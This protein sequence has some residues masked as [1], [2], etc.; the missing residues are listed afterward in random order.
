MVND[1]TAVTSATA[2]AAAMKK[3]TGMNKD[4]FLQLFVTQLKN[5]DPLKPQDSS[6]FIGQLAQLTQVEQS[7]NT[8]TNLGKLLAAANGAQE[9]SAVSFIGKSVVAEGGGFSLKTGDTPTLGFRLPAQAKKVLV[10]IRDVAGKLVRTLT[11]GT[12][13]A[14][15]GVISWDGKDG[16]NRAVPPGTYGYAVTATGSDDKKFDGKPLMSGRVEAV[17][18]EGDEPMLT[19]SGMDVPLSTVLSVKGAT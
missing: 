11:A 16:N 5:Q 4:D 1:A 2:G 17:T 15:D 12:T 18:L 7:Y 3:A 13:P 6:E 19:V 10:E 14:G 9:M 8:N